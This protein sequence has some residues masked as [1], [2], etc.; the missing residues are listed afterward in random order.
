MISK[1]TTHNDGARLAAY[2]TVEKNGE[3]AELWELHG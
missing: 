1:G 2:M 3:R